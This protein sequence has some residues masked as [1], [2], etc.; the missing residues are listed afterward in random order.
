MEM[1]ITGYCVMDNSIGQPVIRHFHNASY[2]E[3]PLTH[4][5][6]LSKST[7]KKSPASY[8]AFLTFCT[9]AFLPLIFDKT[10]FTNNSLLKYAKTV[11]I[12]RTCNPICF[13]VTLKN[14]L[15]G[16]DKNLLLLFDFS[17]LIFQT[18]PTERLQ[19]FFP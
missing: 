4:S 5:A 15:L 8:R 18:V 10:R 17:N 11:F 3:I 6:F 9:P 7:N 12:E 1:C 16:S 14:A 13:P 2:G 19:A